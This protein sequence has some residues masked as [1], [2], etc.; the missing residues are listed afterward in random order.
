[1][2]RERTPRGTPAAG[3]DGQRFPAGVR[4]GAGSQL[5]D[6]VI[7]GAEAGRSR[8]ASGLEI[9]RDALIRRGTAVHEG[10]RAGDR[11]ETGRNVVIEE[12]TSIGDDCRVWH[13]TIIGSECTIGDRVS[14]GANCHIAGLTTIEDGVTIADGV[15]LVNDPHPGSRTHLC[16]RGPT[17]SRHASVGPNATIYP[18]VTIGVGA[19]IEAGSVVVGSVPEGLVVGGNP[20]RILRSVADLTCPLDPLDAGYLAP[21]A[22]DGHRASSLAGRPSAHRSAAARRGGKSRE[23]DDRAGHAERAAENDHRA[24][25]AK[26][27]LDR[28]EHDLDRDQADRKEGEPAELEVAD[29]GR[30]G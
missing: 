30:A 3:I 22:E 27:E 11:L 13:N 20:A 18:F 21:A 15:Y 7:L 25:V 19:L 28:R 8:R 6:D 12:D 23:P 24:A 2:R 5:E 14:I 9:G 26:P 10:V 17:L 29:T 16:A 4:F 1:M